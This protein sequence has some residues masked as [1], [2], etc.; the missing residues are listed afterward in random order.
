MLDPKCQQQINNIVIE[1]DPEL[2]EVHSPGIVEITTNKEKRYSCRVV[3][4]KGH[5]MNPMTNAD[6]EAKFTNLA[7][8]FMP[9]YQ[10]RRIIDTV[11]NLEKVDDIG[12]LLNLLVI[13]A[14]SRSV[15]T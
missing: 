15:K 11:H 9:E 1:P 7:G 12:E 14:G 5:P 3:H 10:M 13:P 2:Y 6:V 8:N 4:P